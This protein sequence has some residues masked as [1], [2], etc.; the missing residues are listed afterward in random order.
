MNKTYGL[1]LQKVRKYCRRCSFAFCGCLEN[2]MTVMSISS[3]VRFC[4]VNY[5][6]LINN[7]RWLLLVSAAIQRDPERSLGIHQEDRIQPGT[8]SVCAGLRLARWQHAGWKSEDAVVQG[9]ESD[10]GGQ[11][12]VHGHDHHGCPGQHRPAETSFR[13]AAATASAGCLQDRR[14]V[15]ELWQNVPHAFTD[16]GNILN[17]ST[18]LSTFSAQLSHSHMFSAFCQHQ[19]SVGFTCPHNLCLPRF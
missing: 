3:V 10:E 18:C 5:F 13:Q 9:L 16:I 1:L 2:W 12:G 15:G 4:C 14:C 7:H 11:E 17:S 8:G 19:S 6:S